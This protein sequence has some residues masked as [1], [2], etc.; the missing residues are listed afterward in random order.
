MWSK[1]FIE[2]FLHHPKHGSST[3][4]APLGPV[5]VLDVGCGNSTMAVAFSRETRLIFNVTATDVS[6]KV[7]EDLQKSTPPPR[8][9][10]PSAC[11][12]STDTSSSIS[13][14]S[15]SSSSSPCSPGSVEFVVADVR[16]MPH[17]ATSRYDLVVE[18]GTLDALCCS[19]SQCFSNFSRTLEEVHRVLKK[20]ATSLTFGHTRNRA[21]DG[22]DTPGGSGGDGDGDGD[23][24]GNGDVP[25]RGGRFISLSYAHPSLRLP[26]YK[27][28]GLPWR[29][30]EV[31]EFASPD[32]KPVYVYTLDVID[33]DDG[34]SV[35]IGGGDDDDDDDDGGK[36][37]PF[38]GMSMVFENPAFT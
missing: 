19:V 3:T 22:E 4:A 13:S 30:H 6:T 8:S 16:N 25:V 11:S 15:S 28:S 36:V 9:G 31:V 38:R 24:E 18:K 29:L 35:D 2:P 26:H 14:S 5:R 34:D 23:I 32:G 10:S 21:S 37:D 12:I 27:R 33:N 20:P 7:I 17:I 1:L